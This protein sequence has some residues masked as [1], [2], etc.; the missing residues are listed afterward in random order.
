MSIKITKFCNIY[1]WLEL[2]GEDDVAWAI[3]HYCLDN[4][5]STPKKGSGLTFL[6]PEKGSLLYSKLVEL[7]NSSPDAVAPM[8]RSLALPLFIDTPSKFKEAT[9]IGIGNKAGFKMEVD[10]IDGDKVI[11]KK[12]NDDK[13]AL[14]I[15][16]NTSFKPLSSIAD[17]VCVWTI[18]SGAPPTSG[19]PYKPPKNKI[20]GGNVNESLQ[21]FIETKCNHPSIKLIG[22]IRA[23]FAQDIEIKYEESIQSLKQ[24]NTS[25]TRFPFWYEAAVSMLIDKVKNEKD[26]KTLKIIAYH[27]TDCP[28]STFYILF[29][30]YKSIGVKLI[31]DS[32]L[33][34]KYISEMRQNINQNVKA[35]ENLGAV[36]N[37]MKSYS[38]RIQQLKDE[39]Y[40]SE[41]IKSSMEF[42]DYAQITLKDNEVGNN[43]MLMSVIKM[44]AEL[45][46]NRNLSLENVNGVQDVI[47]EII[48]EHYKTPNTDSK[49]LWQ[50]ELKYYIS[51]T[52]KL[53]QRT[54]VNKE[55]Q[56]LFIELCNKLKLLYNG[57]NYPKSLM[58]FE[59][60]LL[61]VDYKDH[62][63]T[64]IDFIDSSS[65][66]SMFNVNHSGEKKVVSKIQADNG[67]SP[68]EKSDYENELEIKDLN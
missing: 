6:W 61:R 64:M 66:L 36:I 56:D 47:P 9:K 22:N 33:S 17:R 40:D 2:S 52:I 39:F 31:N 67:L 19:T 35:T 14:V 34:D 16:K 45:Q 7:M 13:E 3:R 8:F 32:I 29:E 41:K 12:Q 23:L 21:N 55:A 68:K 10:K 59:K 11:F 28:V 51:E 18:V 5:I 54:P 25:N 38:S 37:K 49:M 26:E 42:R 60:N 27:S 20:K 43:S 50:D 48:K 15:I 63:R 1:T 65:M 44:Y 62:M 24:G 30:P 46:N 53:I 4:V 58:I 57:D